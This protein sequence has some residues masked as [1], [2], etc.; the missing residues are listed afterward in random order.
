MPITVPGIR[1]MVPPA[2]ALFEER[3]RFWFEG[4][5]GYGS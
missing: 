3:A 1:D 4:G 2:V 5:M